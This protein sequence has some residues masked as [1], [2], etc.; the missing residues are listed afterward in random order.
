MSA[1]GISY[2]CLTTSRKVTLPSVES[3]GTNMN[4]IK[5]PNKGI[6]TRR[7]DKVGETQEVLLAQ[8]NSGDRIAECIN[9]YARGVNP[10]VSVSYDNYGNNGGASSRSHFRK[11][12]VKLPYKPEVFIPPVLRQE[13]LVPLSRLPRNWVYAFS[14]PSMPNLIQESSCSSSKNC[15]ETRHPQFEV[16]T[17]KQYIKELPQDY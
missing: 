15:I 3:W 10:M 5:D 6:Y 4:I 16:D 17:N 7:K 2:D 12:G 8:E 11:Q 1:G 9:V 13:D 14:N